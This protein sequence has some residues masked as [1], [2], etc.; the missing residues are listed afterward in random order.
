MQ[1]I[2]IATPTSAPMTAPTIVLK[3]KKIL[4]V[5]LYFK[6]IEKIENI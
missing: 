5:L 2:N 4:H 1:P 3:K 6:A